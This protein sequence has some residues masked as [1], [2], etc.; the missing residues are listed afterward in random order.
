MDPRQLPT[1]PFLVFAIL[2]A[3]LSSRYMDVTAVVPGEADAFCA[4][5]AGDMSQSGPSSTFIFSSDSDLFVFDVGLSTRLVTFG[6]TEFTKR[7]TTDHLKLRTYCPGSI[8]SSHGLHDLLGP[9]YLMNQDYMLSFKAAVDRVKLLPSPM[10]EGYS[11][12]VE[13]YRLPEFMNETLSSVSETQGALQKTL[14]RLDSRI[15]EFI[16]E[17]VAISKD[18]KPA[19]TPKVDMFLPV[20]V[21]DPARGSA[22]QTATDIRQLAYSLALLSSD[23]AV[24]V[25]E[26]VRKGQAVGPTRSLTLPAAELMEH[27][28]AWSSILQESLATYG[29][30]DNATTWRLLGMKILLEALQRDDK[31]VPVYESS[32]AVVMGKEAKT[33]DE[34]H[35]SAQ[36]EAVLYSF[37]MLKQMLDVAIAKQPI[38]GIDAVSALL[39][40][41]RC[42][43]TL[44]SVAE[45]FD[46][47]GSQRSKTDASGKLRVS[48]K[49]IYEN[50]GGAVFSQEPTGASRKKRKRKKRGSNE[51]AASTPRVPSKSNNPFDVLVD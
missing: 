14:K 27:L 2:E 8:A 15:S 45:L 42:L 10:D 4:K 18:G 20:L 17:T 21:E 6:D 24:H 16:H 22:W 38:C 7:G 13:T 47:S 5:A 37:R 1:P 44:P 41:Q 26:Q 11:A 28:S 12:F 51:N 50:L 9:A 23:Q 19:L 33:W 48:L 29:H 46:C 43:Q 31:N 30:A 49:S 36:L 3:I 32:V 40:L 35:L 34:I 39:E 25:E